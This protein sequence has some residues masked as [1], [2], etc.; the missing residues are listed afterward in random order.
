MEDYFFIPVNSLNF[1]NILSSESL[2]P[3]SFYEKRGFGFKRF[4]HIVANPF[5]NTTLAYS[6][7]IE[8]EAPKSERE[9][10]PIYLAVP[11]SYFNP[12]NEEVKT[13]GLSIIQVS[14]T[15]YI[16]SEECFFVV[17]NEIDKKKIIAGTKRSLEAKHSQLYLKNIYLLKDFKFETEAWNE[18]ILETVSDLK[19]P[20]QNEI[21][22]DQKLNK[23]K[24]F[25][26]GYVLGK[27]KE[28]PAE[29]TEG[30]RYFQ[31]F[32]NTYSALMNE[33][34]VL[35]NESKKVRG[36]N[37]KRRIENEIGRLVDLKERISLLFG[38]NEEI[39]VENAFKSSFE[40]GR[41][42]V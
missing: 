11:K 16:N 26:Y 17:K 35:S 40:I 23:V 24:G 10:F 9:E 28:K 36:V 31:E 29:L 13:N 2:S 38:G 18:S 22:K 7:I 1:N 25:L 3:P 37:H 33:L 32:V 39:E 4:E 14:N 34:S 8:L 6:R 27:L 12:D 15:I 5:L 42:H 21:L 19:N 30:K 41:A 20:N